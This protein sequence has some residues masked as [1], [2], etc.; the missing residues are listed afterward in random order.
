MAS[1][2]SSKSSH[3]HVGR[4]GRSI[5]S[6][7]G[8][9][10]SLFTHPVIGVLVVG[11]ALFCAGLPMEQG[12]LDIYGSIWDWEGVDGSILPLNQVFCRVP[13]DG[14]GF[15]Y[16]IDVWAWLKNFAE[17]IQGAQRFFNVTAN[18]FL[19][20]LG[21]LISRFQ[22]GNVLS[23]V[24][25]VG[26]FIPNLLISLLNFVLVLIK[27]VAFGIMFIFHVVFL[28]IDSGS[29]NAFLDVLSWTI[30]LI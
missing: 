6:S 13:K 1:K 15:W 28:W 20:F 24:L 16:Y 9:I 2:G 12:G 17:S 14:G 11:L 27:G 29:W 5:I 10:L 7:V 19:N 26:T 22:S 3:S 23:I 8:G 18:Q 25:A 21:L 4:T 30:P